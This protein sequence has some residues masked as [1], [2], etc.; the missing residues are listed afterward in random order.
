MRL[1]GRIVSW[2]DSRGFGFIEWN[3]GAD[4]RVFAHISAFEQRRRHPAAG[5]LVTYEVQNDASGRKQ[6]MRIAY[7][8]AV[9]VRSEQPAARLERSTRR[10]PV[11]RKSL[12]LSRLATPLVLVAVAATAYHRYESRLQDTDL[13]V[14]STDRSISGQAAAQSPAQMQFECDGRAHCSEMRS[15]EEATYF[16]RHCPDTKM[17]GDGDHIPCEDQLCGH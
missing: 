12:G 17:D 6:A 8:G 15:C 9:P 16:V 2:N 13:S 10:A 5:D 7:V 14:P 11:A 1:Q 3:G 4:E